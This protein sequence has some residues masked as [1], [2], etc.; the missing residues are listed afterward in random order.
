MGMPKTKADC[1]KAIARAEGEIA[2][3]KAL[4]AEAKRGKNGYAYLDCS[5]DIN[6]RSS[7]SFS[8]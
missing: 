1:D 4:L 2:R 7:I 3:T 8:G 6:P 5:H